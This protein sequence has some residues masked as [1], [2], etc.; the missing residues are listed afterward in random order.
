MKTSRIVSV[1][2]AL[3]LSLPALS[4]GQESALVLETVFDGVSSAVQDRFREALHEGLNTSPHFTVLTE[5]ASR[6]RLGDEA[7]RL[8]SCGDNA[9]C[10]SEAAATSGARL[11]IVSTVEEA[12]EIYT[13]TVNVYE[14]T[15]G[16]SVHTADAECVLCTVEEALGTFEDMGEA[17]A[18]D[19]PGAVAATT[20]LFITA[21]PAAAEIWLNGDSVGQGATEVTVEAGIHELRVVLNGYQTVETEIPVAV[22]DDDKEITVRLREDEG[23][24]TAAGGG[25]SLS[26]SDTTV[27]GSVFVGTGLV[28]AVTGIVLIAIDGNTTCSEGALEDCPEVFE[29]SA[30]GTALT[31]VGSAALTAGIFFLLWESLAG[32]PA[33]ESTDT[34]FGVGPTREGFGFVFGTTF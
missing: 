23:S 24:G 33:P 1:I 8:M 29:T 11:G 28:A 4:W 14:L 21:E 6:Q 25:G 20:T 34:A 15:S 10:L 13:C 30:G 17:A 26:G 7:D 3:S 16:E 9:S 12:G 5:G 32:D 19:F 27:L 22:G 31:V 2:V 18:Q